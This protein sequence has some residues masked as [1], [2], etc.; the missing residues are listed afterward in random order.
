[1]ATD[2]S[3]DYYLYLGHQETPAGHVLLNIYP[4]KTRKVRKKA[5]FSNR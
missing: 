2:Q 1:M 4:L 3:S 5:K